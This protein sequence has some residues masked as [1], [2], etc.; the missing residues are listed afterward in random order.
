MHPTVIIAVII[1][2]VV[3]R[4]VHCQ[5]EER[6]NPETYTINGPLEDQLGPKLAA[7]FIFDIRGQTPD[8]N[9]IV[10]GAIS[11]K[12]E[13]SKTPYMLWDDYMA[14]FRARRYGDP[15][16]NFATHTGWDTF[17]VKCGL[18]PLK[19]LGHQRGGSIQ[20]MGTE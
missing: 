8:N 4:S 2:L 18:V 19:T 16:R 20:P 3:S 11:W 12:T 7:Q 10:Q 17:K 13:R 9:G 15:D 14:S 6:R 1:A 5:P